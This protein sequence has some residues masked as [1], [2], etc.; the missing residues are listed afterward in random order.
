MPERIKRR[1]CKEDLV[2]PHEKY[3]QREIQKGG[4]FKRQRCQD[5]EGRCIL[6]RDIEK[7]DS[8]H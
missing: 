4:R 3:C 6:A 5:S 7:V 1:H 8:G 2:G